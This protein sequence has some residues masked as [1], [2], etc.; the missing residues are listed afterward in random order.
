MKVV[1]Q[2][3][4]LKRGMEQRGDR[5]ITI[6]SLI[7]K[8]GTEER[9]IKKRERIRAHR[10]D[11]R[12]VVSHVDFYRPRGFG[13]KKKNGSTVMKEV[14]KYPAAWQRPVPL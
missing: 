2:E 5:Q 1:A 9:N 13:G 12:E 10:K 14:T 4:G 6:I 11:K 3:Q 7:K 8:Y